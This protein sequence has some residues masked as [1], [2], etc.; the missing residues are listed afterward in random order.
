MNSKPTPIGW[1][2]GKKAHAQWEQQIARRKTRIAQIASRLDRMGEIE[3]A[4]G[5]SLMFSKIRRDKNSPMDHFC[6][7][8][9]STTKL[10]QEFERVKNS[11]KSRTSV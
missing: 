9:T 4:A 11:S 1:T 5:V 6:G 7:R 3:E 2:A 8:N 10:S